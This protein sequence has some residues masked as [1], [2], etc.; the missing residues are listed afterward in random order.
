MGVPA[1]AQ[2]VKDLLLPQLCHRLHLRLGF[3]P[4]P[5]NFHMAM[6]AAE[7]EKKKKKN[8]KKWNW[9]KR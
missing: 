7:S 5:R 4:W 6:D 2:W 8:R 1:V 9:I 3:N